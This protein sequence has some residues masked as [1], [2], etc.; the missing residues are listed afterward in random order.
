MA[1]ADVPVVLL[2][3]GLA[4]R[5]Y[6]TEP[7]AAQRKGEFEIRVVDAETKQPI[8]ANLFLRNARGRPVRRPSSRS[9]RT[10]SSFAGS[11]VLELASRPVYV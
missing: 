6:G 4:G 7:G 9:G 1:V 3:W 5:V 10:I 11:V 8:A 2:V